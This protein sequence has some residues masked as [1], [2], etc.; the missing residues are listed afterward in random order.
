MPKTAGLSF[1]AV[2][3]DAYGGGF[4]AD[5]DDY[6]LAASPDQRL[7]VSI[8]Y[9]LRAR[10]DAF[11]SVR[12]VHGHFLPLKYLLLGD[13]IECRFVTWLREPVA[14]L[15]SHYHYWSRHYE[16]DAD[17]TSSLHRRVIEEGWTLERF[18]LAPELRNVYS[19]F[20]RGFPLRFLDFVG[21]SEFYTEDLREFSTRFLGRQAEPMVLNAAS[22]RYRAEDIPAGLRRRVR[23]YHRQDVELYEHAL[24]LRQR[25][26]CASAAF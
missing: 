13:D 10:A 9:A 4:L 5:Y 14:R 15:V 12:C 2:L 7:A 17:S 24:V 20:L 6:P 11:A 26:Q 23:A 8:D 1:R 25:R 22:V 3:E 21:I 18:C 16:P 19:E